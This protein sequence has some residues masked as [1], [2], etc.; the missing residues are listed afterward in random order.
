MHHTMAKKI[1]SWAPNTGSETRKVEVRFVKLCF[2][3]GYFELERDVKSVIEVREKE[4]ESQNHTE[5][6]GG[7]N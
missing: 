6:V 3:I 5:G 4:M 7:T 2:C 1:W